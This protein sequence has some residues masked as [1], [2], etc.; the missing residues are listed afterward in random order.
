MSENT[1]LDV[2]QIKKILLNRYPILYIDK[3]FTYEPGKSIEGL[4]NLTFNEDF[5]QGHFPIMP[6]M[7]GALMVETTAQ[8]AAALLYLSQKEKGK[9]FFLAGIEKTR[10]RKFA[11]PG[12][13]L[14]IQAD[15]IKSRKNLHWFE[16]RI[17]VEGKKIME[18]TISMVEHE[19]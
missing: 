18:T 7:P 19:L 2:T 13:Q 8:L 12:D 16:A 14:I 9:D 1:V 5:F 17:S 6:I 10:F 11:G 3:I 15:C 4:K